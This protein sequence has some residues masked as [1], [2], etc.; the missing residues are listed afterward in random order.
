MRKNHRMIFACGLLTLALGSIE[1]VHAVAPA[2]PSRNGLI[3][4][5]PRP[6]GQMVG[7]ED[8]ISYILSLLTF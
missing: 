1:S 6:K 3:R 5:A 7:P 8:L 4:S 2:G